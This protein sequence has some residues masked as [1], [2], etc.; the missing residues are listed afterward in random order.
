M[1]LKQVVKWVVN[2]TTLYKL[3]QQKDNAETTIENNLSSYS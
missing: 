3:P 1:P 2:I